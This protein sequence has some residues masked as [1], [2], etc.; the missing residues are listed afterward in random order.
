[1]NAERVQYLVIIFVAIAS[2]LLHALL[3]KKMLFSK[4]GKSFSQRLIV[5]SVCY[6]VLS[7]GA[8]VVSAYL[9]LFD[10]ISGMFVAFYQ[11]KK[12]FW[13]RLAVYLFAFGLFWLMSAVSVSISVSAL[14]VERL[15]ALVSPIFYANHLGI[16]FS[17][18]TLFG[19]LG[20]AACVSAI[21]CVLEPPLELSANCRLVTCLLHP[22]AIMLI[23]VAKLFASCV[24]LLLAIFV[25]VAIHRYSKARPSHFRRVSKFICKISMLISQA[26]F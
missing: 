25:F 4:L 10:E 26:N 6:M 12:L 5:N 2:C 7:I 8:L 1:M 19:S 23:M 22:T 3:V 17:I 15:L 18:L 11:T 14:L 9:V 20:V 16:G 24:N 21:I 13:P